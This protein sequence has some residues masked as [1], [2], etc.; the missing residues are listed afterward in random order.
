MPAVHRLVGAA[1]AL[2]AGRWKVRAGRVLA[3]TA[4]RV[5]ASPVVD[6][7]LADGTAM[8]L[9]SRGRTEGEAVWNGTFDPDTIAVL[10][11]STP[12]DGHLLDVGANVG[13]VALPMA[14]HLSAGGGSVTAVEPVAVNAQRIRES[15]ALNDVE[16]TVLETALGDSDGNVDIYRDRGLGSATGN[17]IM[18][19]AGTGYGE[20]TQVP[21][22][23]LDA[24]VDREHIARIDVIKLDIEGAEILFL[25]GAA[26]TI[27]RDRPTIVGE[28]NAQ[29]MPRFGQTFADV[30][31]FL[32]A[33][34]Y[35]VV[36]FAADGHPVVV[37]PEPGRGNVAL[38]PH[39]KLEPFMAAIR[40]VAQA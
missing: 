37:D 28:F 16:V 26:G 2:P 33:W 12:P 6:V 22:T 25:R 8:R 1:R 30:R 38:V 7:R 9:D 40:L 4:A 36:A 21:L 5:G 24:L 29:L 13:L 32:D 11:V 15:A 10:K 23:T 34:D 31:P 14:R 39:E 19:A 27:R 3:A 20:Q 17:A 18:G 35:A